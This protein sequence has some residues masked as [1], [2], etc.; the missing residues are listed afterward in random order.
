LWR[1]NYSTLGLLNWCVPSKTPLSGS[2]SGLCQPSSTGRPPACLTPLPCVQFRYQTSPLSWLKGAT[3]VAT[4]R[5]QRR[6]EQFLD[7]AEEAVARLDWEIVRDRT[8]AVL[9]LD[10]ENADGLAL[11][12]AAERELGETSTPSARSAS[13]IARPAAMSAIKY[14]AQHQTQN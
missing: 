6:I 10:Q 7:E 2:S 13:T 12:A 9:G 1:W 5:L 4:E 8:K 14:L 3:A 11:L